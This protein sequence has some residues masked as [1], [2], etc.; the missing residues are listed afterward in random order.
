MSHGGILLTLVDEADPEMVDIVVVVPF[1]GA[2][3]CAPAGFGS[4]ALTLKFDD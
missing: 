3:D 2:F 4:G 1:T